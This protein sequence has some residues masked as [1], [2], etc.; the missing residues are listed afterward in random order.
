M[1][2]RTDMGGSDFRYLQVIVSS[3]DY[4]P[5]STDPLRNR[6]VVVIDW[7]ALAQDYLATVNSGQKWTM[8][9]GLRN[10]FVWSSDTA[11]LGGAIAYEYGTKGNI[12]SVSLET[13]S[14]ILND[15]Y[16]N[17]AGQPIS[18]AA[19]GNLSSGPGPAG[20][21]EPQSLTAEFQAAAA[22]SG[23]EREQV[24]GGEQTPVLPQV[25]GGRSKLFEAPRSP[26]SP[27]GARAPTSRS[28]IEQSRGTGDRTT[29]VAAAGG[30]VPESSSF[31][32]HATPASGGKLSATSAVDFA[33]SFET[34]SLVK[35]TQSEPTL[36]DRSD[37]TETAYSIGS[38]WTV[39][40]AWG[41]LQR[42]LAS[43]AELGGEATEYSM[44][45]LDSSAGAT[46]NN[47][48]AAL[49]SEVTR[50]VQKA[51]RFDLAHFA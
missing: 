45:P 31:S 41:Q 1:E 16:V 18:L 40:D 46:R 24:S 8:E 26:N 10:H 28:D 20:A 48:E 37:A 5:T 47:A 12:N 11:A 22:P 32:G 3:S 49:G 50:M 36:R 51:A 38:R 13:R 14:A 25:V 7:P 9:T 17:V 33:F 19:Y 43:A 30:Q 21:S 44:L 15:P 29:N 35:L 2:Y 6:K 42:A 23:P 34:P 39:V 4:A 27:S